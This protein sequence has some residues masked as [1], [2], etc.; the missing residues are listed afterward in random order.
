LALLKDVE[1]YRSVDEFL[2]KM[3]S[4][5]LDRNLFAEI[6]KLSRK[7]LK[8]V[9]RRLIRRENKRYGLRRFFDL[10]GLTPASSAES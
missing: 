5:V 2:A 8:E 3:D 10:K 4:G 6:R 9:A 7:Q 1:A